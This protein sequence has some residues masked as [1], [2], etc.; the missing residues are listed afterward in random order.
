MAQS[1]KTVAIL[2]V[3]PALNSL[4]AGVLAESRDLRVRSFESELALQVY[5]R[6]AK[7]DLVV[8]DSDGIGLDAIWMLRNDADS[9]SPDF[10]TIVLTSLISQGF[11]EECA[12]AGVSEVIV[13]PMS[14]R[15]LVERVQARLRASRPQRVAPRVR[16]AE[17]DYSRFANV[18]PLWTKDRP[19]P[20]L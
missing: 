15:H 5:M 3:Q 7:V 14:P 2:A 10:S 13:K 19:R 8:L 6:I 11:R 16:V 4:L 1:L 20:V 12:G 17:E 9:E 18:V